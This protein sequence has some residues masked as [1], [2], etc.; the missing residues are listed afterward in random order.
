MAAKV[1]GDPKQTKEE[2]RETEKPPGPPER[3]IDDHA[4]EEFMRE[5]H[6]SK[7]EDGGLQ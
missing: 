1:L 7:G 6:R 4:I 5:Q 2:K 3:P